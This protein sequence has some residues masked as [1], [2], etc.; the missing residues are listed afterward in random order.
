MPVFNEEIK[1]NMVTM[2]RTRG[3]LRDLEDR[4]SGVRNL[5]TNVKNSIRREHNMIR[6]H[7]S[8]AEFGIRVTIVTR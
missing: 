3:L 2:T 5:T 7:R 1:T 6:E 4:S 8:N